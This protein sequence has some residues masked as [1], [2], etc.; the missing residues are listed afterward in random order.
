M[1]AARGSTALLA[2]LV[3]VASLLTGVPS[4]T[5]APPPDTGAPTTE[6]KIEPAVMA[7]L[8]QE[9]TTGYWVRVGEVP[10]TSAAREIADWEER[11]RYVYETLRDAA[12][13]DQRPVR[14]LLEARGVEYEA[15]WLVNAIFVPEGT[16]DLATD[17][18]RAPA[19][20]SI[21]APTSYTEPDP[22]TREVDIEA[23]AAQVEWGIA[24]INADDVWDEYGVT[25]EG[26]TVA[27]IDSG[28][29]VTHPGLL[30]HYRGYRPDGSLD[31]D[32]NWLD[33]TGY[34][35]GA[36]CD[37]DGHGTHTMG[38]MVGGDDTD[39]FGVAPGATWIAANGCCTSDATLIASAEWMLAPTKVNG[40]DPDPAR[41]P[42]IINNS[43]GSRTPSNDPFLEDIQQAWMDA[44]IFAVWSNGNNGPE[45]E[46]SGSPGSRTLSYSVGAHDVDN[47]VA[48][49]SSRGP[50]QDGSVKPDISAPGDEV[51]SSFPGGGFAIGSGTSMAA[52]HVSGAVALLWAG[53]PALIGDIEATRDLL[54]ST[55]VDTPDDQCGGTPENNNV[56]GEGRLDALAL[57]EAG[58]RGGTLTGTVV[59][60][61]GD[62]VAGADVRATQG[63]RVRTVTTDGDGGFSMILADGD[64][65]LSATAFGYTTATAEVTLVGGETTRQD[66]TLERLPV[67]TLTGTVTDAAT[68]EPVYGA[69]V[70]LP[71]TPLA[72]ARTGVDGRYS[73]EVPVGDYD[74][75]AALTHCTDPR[76]TE[77]T[78]GA[79]TTVDLALVRTTDTYG[80]SC[81]LEPAAYVEADQP[82]GLSPDH[83]TTAIDLPFPITWYGEVYTEKAYVSVHGHVNF[84]GE[85]A[86]PFA[87]TIPST[88]GVNAAAYPFWRPSKPGEGGGVFTTV[89]GEAP[90]RGLVVEYRNM[91]GQYDDA[92]PVD[93]EVTFWED[94][95]V[96]FAYRNLDPE[97]PLEL[98]GN[99]SIGI[100]SADG[101]EGFQYSYYEESLS[102]SDQIRFSYPPS[103]F[104]E[105]TVTSAADGTPVEGA[106][107]VARDGSGTALRTMTTGA[108]GAYRT[109][110]PIGQ[111][112]LVTS[113]FGY[114]TQT[115]EVTVVDG[116]VREPIVLE[117][118]STHT[119]TGVVSAAGEPVAGA[120]V[121]VEDTPLPSVTTGSDGSYAIPDVP[122][123]T[124][125]VTADYPHCAVPQSTEVAV[126]GPLT[127]D[128]DL[129]RVT[130]EFGYTCDLEPAAYVEVD[131]PV[132]LSGDEATTSV[133]LPFPVTL[134]GVGYS[135]VHL[136]TNGEISFVGPRTWFSGSL[137]NPLAPNGAVYPFWSNLEIQEHGGVYT[138]VVGEAPN[139]GFVIEYRDVNLW[140]G[141]GTLDFEATLWENG[142]ITFAYRDLDEEP[143]GH[144]VGAGATVGLENADGTVA[145]QYS[146]NERSLSDDRQIRFSLPANDSV[147]GR[148]TDANDGT[149]I[150]EA[151][152]VVT[153]ED[154]T[155]VR[156]MR[157]A[158]D[159]SYRTLLFPG[160]YTVTAS[161]LHHEPSR[162][163]VTV[164]GSGGVVT[165]DHELATATLAAELTGSDIVVAR[166]GTAVREVTITNTGSAD[167]EWQLAEVRAGGL[168]ASSEE[169]AE[170]DR[171][172]GPTVQDRR[173]DL[174]GTRTQDPTAHTTAG[175]AVGRRTMTATAEPVRPEVVAEWPA[176]GVGQGFGVGT[177]GE[178]V[179]VSDLAARRNTEFGPDGTPTGVSHRADWAEFWHADMAPD[180]DG[181][182]CQLS[183]G[184]IG[185][186]NGIHCWDPAT[187][188]VVHAVH[189]L[190][191]GDVSQRG[192]A[193]DAAEDIFYVGG[194]N[195]GVVYAVAGRSFETPGA[196]LSH[197]STA[198]RAIAGLGF[199]PVR[200]TLWVATN[201]ETDTIYEIDPL[202]CSTISA[203]GDPGA[204]PYSGAGLE[205]DPNGDLWALDQAEG[206]VRR[207]ATGSPSL[208]DVPWLDLSGTSGTVAPGES[209]TVTVTLEPGDLEPGTYEASLLVSGTAGGSPFVEV[210]V[211]MVVS[212]YLQAVNV[213]G[214]GYVD[215]LGD[216]W[217]ADRAHTAG[218][219][220]HVG[221]S[222]TK[223]TKVAITGTEDDTMFQTRRD[224]EFGYRF[225]EA[226][227]GTYRID[228][229]FASFKPRETPGKQL[230]DVRVNGT[231]VLDDHDVIASAGSQAADLQTVT[232]EHG[233]GPLVIDLVRVRG[234]QPL[235]NA[236]R[237]THRGQPD[238]P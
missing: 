193:Y 197:C 152:V 85:D 16:A 10:D 57:L 140:Y 220:G 135:R 156:R 113:A 184:D 93:F 8:E 227:A 176:E 182:V 158:A 170:T 118:A 234:P 153:D 28:V 89:T 100:E 103:G 211:T 132:E 106:T 187:G 117:V 131:T 91:V 110:L 230:F 142:E 24:N 126:E 231:T 6:D 180:G 77:V 1:S 237:V 125:T 188:E 201:S 145:F 229:G 222:T 47:L 111:W 14:E 18:A 78:V 123:E 151:W 216:T 122:A 45:C 219:W 214:A 138:G 189:G 173:Q 62:P 101:R 160:S 157:T 154:G 41:R 102:E 141:D 92:A 3:L 238:V 196:T 43:W 75:T 49:F 119:I 84:L 177:T 17:L 161:R 137:P 172:V 208:G 32:Y 37:S 185:G 210:P 72:P 59:D 169:T 186:N 29:D 159:G 124:Y 9:D 81:A 114:V 15:H 136:G 58:P 143:Y 112:E 233:G 107:V 127:Q 146:F 30:R 203:L 130:D 178:A 21:I 79:D 13:A 144:E 195:E 218:S 60:T 23:A 66:L 22:V 2:L 166:N 52:P 150:A 129:E 26:I 194:W 50:G 70:E 105:G 149:G 53:S 34:C 202:T 42:H 191:W 228:L 162:Q 213:G 168:P 64:W 20:E 163:E 27:N 164:T 12:E 82:L 236:L 199:D 48:E 198:D 174:T 44:G 94:H 76:T 116:T 120:V 19:V 55:A 5:A 207:I 38:T 115:R 97:D 33:T 190:P 133:D 36:P 71:G 206:V 223:S 63:D 99:A 109:E 96:T 225:D 40:Q 200:R 128:F 39:H 56:Y 179:W 155:V 217:G 224:G 148:V 11:G 226:P 205:V 215:V 221:R 31:H 165:L 175:A 121:T 88:W 235:L 54:D 61:D 139:R 86:Q 68:G 104:V 183:V 147:T 74:V 80:Y 171:L 212:E 167:L 4:A 87:G 25:G 108:D 46:T 7:A 83:P 204:Q 51:R 95:S 69:T 90:H 181:N 65:E 98:G 192:L 73:I 209:T 67:F 35:G 134:Y 232:V